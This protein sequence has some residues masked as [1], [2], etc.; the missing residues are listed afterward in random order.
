M[1]VLVA[2]P[3]KRMM[4]RLQVPELLERCE[5]LAFEYEKFRPAPSLRSSVAY[6]NVAIL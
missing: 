5:M 1:A 2:L 3:Q 6:A 4:V